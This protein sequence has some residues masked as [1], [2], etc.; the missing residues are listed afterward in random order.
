MTGGIM[1]IITLIF[2]VIMSRIQKVSYYS[3]LIK[4]ILLY[5][6]EGEDEDEDQNDEN[7]KK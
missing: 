3:T 2:A 4:N 7:A 5:Q 6:H 1:T